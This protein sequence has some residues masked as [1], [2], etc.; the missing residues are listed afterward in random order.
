MHN[1]SAE[2]R[3]EEGLSKGDISILNKSKASATVVDKS[4]QVL[5]QQV[6]Q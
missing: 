2:S 5:H 4:L 3:G 1:K 6:Q